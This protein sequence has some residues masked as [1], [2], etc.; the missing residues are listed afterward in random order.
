M[1]PN[2]TDQLGR[3]PDA[4]FLKKTVTRRSYSCGAVPSA[5]ACSAPGTSHNSFGPMA[6]SKILL[7]CRHGIYRSRESQISST[8]KGRV[9]TA[10][11]GDTSS[12]ENPPF[13]SPDAI[14][15]H[16]AG[17]KRVFPSHGDQCRPA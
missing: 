2:L 12:A 9:A 7:E 13:F 11:S 10:F 3:A 17:R 14:A 16:T 15:V 1:D 4:R 5:A 8:G 6:A